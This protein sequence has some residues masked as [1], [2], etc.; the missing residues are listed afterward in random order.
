[1]SLSSFCANVGGVAFLLI[2]AYN[3]NMTTE[4]T[5]ARDEYNIRVPSQGKMARSYV[6][7]PGGNIFTE[8]GIAVTHA[9][10][11]G[12]LA[13]AT[14]VCEHCPAL[15]YKERDPHFVPRN[16]PVVPIQVDG[17]GIEQGLLCVPV[18]GKPRL[19]AQMSKMKVS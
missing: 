15:P 7:V 12:L 17:V 13:F 4:N 10:D 5:I 6:N 1:M 14:H 18:S 3:T 16:R 19:C 2:L 8:N 11:E 9:T